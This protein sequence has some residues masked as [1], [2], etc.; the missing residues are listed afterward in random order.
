MKVKISGDLAD[1]KSA[2]V[3]LQ[4]QLKGVGTAGKSAGAEASSGLGGIGKSIAG[5]VGGYLSFRTLVGG[6]GAIVQNTI[7][8]ERAQAQLRAALESSAGAAGLTVDELNA[9]ASSLQQVSKFDDDAITGAQTLLLQFDRIGRDVFPRATEAVLDFAE[10]MGVD[11]DAA[12]KTVGKALQDPERGLKGLRDAGVKLTD[13][14][15]E[16]IERLSKVGDVAGAQAIVLDE[17]AEKMGGAAAASRD[18]LGGALQGLKNDFANLLEGDSGGAGVRGATSSI[19]ELAKT[20]RSPA[21]Q[22]GFAAIVQG[23]GHLATW[24]AQAAASIGFLTQALSANTKKS[25]DGLLYRLYEIDDAIGKIKKRGATSEGLFGL[26]TTLEDLGRERDQV[27]KLLEQFRAKDSP[28]AS[29]PPTPAFVTMEEM[30]IDASDA[31]RAADEAKRKVEALR[32]EQERLRKESERAEEARKKELE[33]LNERIDAGMKDVEIALQRAA[34]ND[35]VAAF[36]EVEQQYAQL[37]ED[38]KTKGDQSSLD[39]VQRLINQ[40]KFQAE[41]NEVL[42]KADAA[43]RAFGT[44]V[45]TSEGAVNAGEMTGGDADAAIEESARRQTAALQDARAKALEYYRTHSGPEAQAAL[46][47]VGRIDDQIRQLDE[48]HQTFGEF[49]KGQAVDALTGFFTDLATGAKSFKDAF[50]DMVRN[51]IAGIA[52]MIAQ[53][54]ALKAVDAI[55]GMFH[56]GG[57]VGAGGT[58]RSVD[59]M[60]FFAAPRFHGGGIAGLGPNEMPAILERGEEVLTRRDARHRANGGG[61]GGRTRT[62]IVA[63]GDRAIADALAGAAGEAVVVTHVRNNWGGL[64]GGQLA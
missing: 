52:Q 20:M 9:M 41:L 3:G 29:T 32:R 58:L 15:A 24:A 17:L 31:N 11:L 5:I 62:P 38:L 30:R 64:T 10:R 1:I 61:Q 44:T 23:L 63:I 50:L 35:A 7:D 37:I 46:E 22:D 28:A 55:V 8:A 21:V 45:A 6:I 54:L 47:A 56:G 36:M 42:S 33:A 34:G 60:A 57:I 27:Q 39:L 26:G 4:Q 43:M 12:A 18:T 48:A 19:N 40:E 2:L 16:L 49:V 25:Y 14:Q 13:E 51:F 53:K 59:P